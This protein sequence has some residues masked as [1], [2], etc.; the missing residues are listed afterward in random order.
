[1]AYIFVGGSSAAGP[2]GYTPVKGVDYWSDDDIREIT[3]TVAKYT[4]TQIANLVNSAPETLDTLGELAIAFQENEEVVNVLNDAIT[5][6]AD[7]NT[8]LYKVP[9]ELTLDEVNQVRQNIHSVGQYTEG[10]TYYPFNVTE[11]I[12][13][14]N[15]TKELLDPVIAKQGAEIYNDYENN[16]A[17]GMW[18][19]ASGCG[20]QALGDFSDAS[21]WLTKA[22]AFCS[23]SS[24]RQTIAS[25]PYSHAEGHATQALKNDSHA[26][27]EGSVANG[28]RAHAEG[29]FTQANHN[30]AH[31]E[32]MNT[33]ASGINSHAEGWGTTASGQNA[34]S[35]GKNTLASGTNSFANGLSTIAAGAQQVVHGKYNVS[36][37]TSLMIVG[38]GTSDT[39]RSNAYTLDSNGNAWFSGEVYIGSIT[40]TNKDDGSKK[41]A[42]E[43]Y[44]SEEVD[45]LN[46]SITTK[47]SADNPPP[48]PVTSVQGKTGV[49]MFTTETWTFT[50]ADGTTVTKKVLLGD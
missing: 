10:L 33:V 11:V 23:I 45:T 12:D 49:V 19:V 50:L 42:T 6:K 48:Y 27:G 39:D 7:A 47:Y 9:Q 22:T 46:Q 31:S 8:V 21:G 37:T 28:A 3:D 17:T 20:N 43:E 32:G 1:M 38:N 34:F 44:V 13:Y 30:Q 25:G 41:L 36:D 16:I 5:T 29:Y 15:F 18:A 24:G 40:G 2:P 4:D 14:E 26:E 35:G